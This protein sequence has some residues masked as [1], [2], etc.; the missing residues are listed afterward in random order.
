MGSTIDHHN[1]QRLGGRGER[2]ERE[3]ER[4]SEDERTVV[5]NTQSTKDVANHV[6]L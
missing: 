2:G 5:L 3:R 1:N 4:E 6:A